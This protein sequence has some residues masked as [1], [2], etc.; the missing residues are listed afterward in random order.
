M[1]NVEKHNNVRPNVTIEMKCT[2]SFGMRTWEKDSTRRMW[3]DNTKV[4]LE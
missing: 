2:Q 1:E 3:E 4:G